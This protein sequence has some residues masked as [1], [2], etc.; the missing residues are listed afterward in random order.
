MTVSNTTQALID[1]LKSR[2]ASGLK[3]Y[4]TT[5]DR[6]DLSHAEWLQHMAEELLDAAGYALAAKREAG[7]IESAIR[8]VAEEI[9]SHDGGQSF[10]NGGFFAL[11]MLQQE[12]VKLER[13]DG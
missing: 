9:K 7:R 12:L 3:K 2:D 8:S 6:G 10:Q 11:C 1:L 4:G 13:A 5:L